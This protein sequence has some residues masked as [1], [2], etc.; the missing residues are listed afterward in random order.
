MFGVFQYKN[1]EIRIGSFILRNCSFYKTQSTTQPQ[2]L[3]EDL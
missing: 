2:V 1:I 3:L